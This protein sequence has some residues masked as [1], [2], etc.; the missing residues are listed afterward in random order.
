MH[1]E[2]RITQAIRLHEAKRELDIIETEIGSALDKVGLHWH[3]FDSDP[4]DNVMRIYATHTTEYSPEQVELMWKLGFSAV[5]FHT[6]RPGHSDN[7]E[8]FYGKYGNQQAS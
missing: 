8:T 5:V 4:Y 6:T 2:R 7:V 3:D 1:Q